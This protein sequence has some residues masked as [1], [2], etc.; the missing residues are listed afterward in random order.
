MGADD[1]AVE[2]AAKAA[3][4]HDFICGFPKGYDTVIGELGSRLSG[5]EKQ[6]ICIARALLKNAPVL[7]LDEATSA[8]DSQAEKVV[9][10]ALE[11]LMEGR[12]SFVIAHRLSTIDYASRIIVLENGTIV[13]QGV[14]DD[15]MAAKGFYYKLQSMQTSKN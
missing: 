15:L 12:T 7:I 8:L 1:T 4:A 10:K 6:R 11:N 9:Q 14:H 13:E 5:G 2:A 3:F